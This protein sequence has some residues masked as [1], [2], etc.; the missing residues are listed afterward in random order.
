M[1]G[2]DPSGEK[3]PKEKVVETVDYRSPAAA[4]EDKITEKRPVEIVHEIHGGEKYKN[5]AS[6][7]KQD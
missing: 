6:V 3:L 1:A 5:G 7:P 2:D 4:E